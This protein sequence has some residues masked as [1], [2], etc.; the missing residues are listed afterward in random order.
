MASVYMLLHISSWVLGVY[1][2][3]AGAEGRCVLQGCV[4]LGFRGRTPHGR[5]MGTCLHGVLRGRV[6]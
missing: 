5:A 3:G 4:K 6:T 1:G 2:L